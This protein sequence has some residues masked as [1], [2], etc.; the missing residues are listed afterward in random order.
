MLLELGNKKQAIGE[1]IKVA[2]L[3]RKVGQIQLANAVGITQGYLSKIE[4]GKIDPSAIDWFYLSDVLKFS[5]DSIT[6]GYPELMSPL[7]PM[8]DIVTTLKMP[9]T[10]IDSERKI[11][12]RFLYPMIHFFEKTEKKNTAKIKIEKIL[13]DL[14]I[15]ILAMRVPFLWVNHS[16]V[17]CFLESLFSSK[18]TS[19][20]ILK[21]IAPFSANAITWSKE[22]S[23]I[24]S[25]QLFSDKLISLLNWQH[26]E[27]PG[28]SWKIKNDP[29]NNISQVDLNLAPHFAG[30]KIGKILLPFTTNKIL[31][32]INVMSKDNKAF[33]SQCS[34]VNSKI[35]WK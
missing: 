11:S 6:W 5:P 3:I 33:I 7:P 16:F 30:A 20:K 18:N 29:Y 31:S 10:F 15:S 23:I 19:S 13:D 24:N 9:Q 27:L 25:T 1:I 28:F 2:R 26:Q 22:F 35:I 12:M 34:E 4:S 32:M 8:E 14:E 21:D 17:D